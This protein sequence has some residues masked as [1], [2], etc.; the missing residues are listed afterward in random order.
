MTPGTIVV[1]EDSEAG[2]AHIVE[3]LAFNATESFSNHQI[4]K[5]LESIGAG[6]GA[7]QNA[8]TS[9]DETCYQLVL[10]VS[11]AAS[12]A[13]TGSTAATATASITASTP[14]ATPPA[15]LSTAGAAGAEE[16]TA[17]VEAEEGGAEASAGAAEAEVAAGAAGAEVAAGAGAGSQDLKLLQ[18]ALKVLA[19]FAFRISTSCPLP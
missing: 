4:V 18:E 14:P 8:Y 19:E 16:L 17:A 1:E 15:V 11:S 3:H 7:C 9:S 6:F 12:T 10:P 13:T 5:F 2:V